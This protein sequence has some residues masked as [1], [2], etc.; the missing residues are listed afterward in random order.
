MKRGAPPGGA[1]PFPVVVHAPAQQEQER[2]IKP[3]ELTKS[4]LSGAGSPAD[5][6]RSCLGIAQSEPSSDPLLPPSS[7]S[8]G[9]D[10]GGG[11]DEQRRDQDSVQKPPLISSIGALSDV[12][13]K[14]TAGAATPASSASPGVFLVAPSASGPVP[15]PT[16]PAA[17][18]ARTFY[19]QA[20]GLPRVTVTR[21]SSGGGGTAAGSGSGS[22]SGPAIIRRTSGGGAPPAPTSGLSRVGAAAGEAPAP[23]PRSAA[24]VPMSSSSAFGGVV[25]AR[26]GGQPGL[27]QR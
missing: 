8:A 2:P 24:P 21:G 9:G 10:R 3:W 26:V 4:D 18:D 7:A 27:E 15:L 16:Q 23:R 17:T 19:Q 5:A 1:N 11:G 25:G 22:G 14:P 6:A 13:R 12:Q 20:G